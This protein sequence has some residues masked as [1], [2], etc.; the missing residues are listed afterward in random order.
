MNLMKNLRNCITQYWEED[1]TLGCSQI[2]LATVAGFCLN[3][4]LSKRLLLPKIS[5]IKFLPQSLNVI[6]EATESEIRTVWSC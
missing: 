6:Y 2:F 5:Q 3:K 4:S 1:L